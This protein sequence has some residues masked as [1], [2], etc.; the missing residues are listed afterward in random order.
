MI[1]AAE[2]SR[3]GR[4]TSVQSAAKCGCWSRPV[5]RCAQLVASLCPPGATAFTTL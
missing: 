1:L 3:G 5:V 4:A 2:T